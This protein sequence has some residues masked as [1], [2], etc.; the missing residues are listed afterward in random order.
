MD[1]HKAWLVKIAK[2]RCLSV[3]TFFAWRKCLRSMDG[4]KSSCWCPCTLW[5]PK[6]HLAGHS[7]TKAELGRSMDRSSVPKLFVKAH[8]SLSEASQ[9]RL[10]GHGC[11]WNASLVPRRGLLSSTWLS[12]SWALS[13]RSSLYSANSSCYPRKAVLFWSLMGS[14]REP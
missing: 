13:A 6:H 1:L 7:R 11:S 8:Q 9:A 2:A 14:A 5:W 3:H 4:W 12:W 10:M